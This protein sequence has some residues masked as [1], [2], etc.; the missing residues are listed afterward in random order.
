MFSRE[1]FYNALQ[2]R[3]MRN[4]QNENHIEDIY[5]G[6]IHKAEMAE[7][8]FLQNPNNISFMWYTDGIAIYKSNKFSVWVMFLMINEVKYKTRTNQENVVLAG[9]WFGR[10]KQNQI[11]FCL[12]FTMI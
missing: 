3:F 9:L 10:K 5:D 2:F 8:G 11:C 12:H 4:K 6:E 7:N 1:D